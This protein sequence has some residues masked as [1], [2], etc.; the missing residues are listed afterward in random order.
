M[1][2]AII[3]HLAWP[4]WALSIVKTGLVNPI[5]SIPIGQY[6][7]PTSAILSWRMTPMRYC[8]ARGDFIPRFL[9]AGRVSG[10]CLSLLLLEFGR[11]RL[12]HD[13]IGLPT[14]SV[15]H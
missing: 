8:P 12:L 10:I 1:A 4:P 7:T 14:Y 6:V 13:R 2:A 9:L 15:W 5:G 3:L 11:L